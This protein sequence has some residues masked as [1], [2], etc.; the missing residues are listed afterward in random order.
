MLYA[1]TPC[2][3]RKFLET[4]LYGQP[5]YGASSEAMCAVVKLDVS[6]MKTSVR[7]DSS[8]SRGNAE[9]RV[10]V[11][12][13]LFPATQQIAIGDLVN[14]MGYTVEIMSV[15]PRLTVF[16]ALDHFEADLATAEVE[17]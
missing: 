13:L 11:G 10:S 17:F 4:D 16:G 1:R 8:A 3:I 15:Q 5:S 2:R 7:T 6:A 9:E 12:R 14:L